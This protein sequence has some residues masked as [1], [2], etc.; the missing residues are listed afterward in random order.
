MNWRNPDR[1]EQWADRTIDGVH[2]SFGHL[3]PFDM[4][5]R[6][7]A[8]GALPPMDI[9]IRVVFD[10]HVVTE[11]VEGIQERPPA[12]DAAYWVDC[13]GNKRRFHPDRYRCSQLLSDLIRGLPDGRTK[14]YMARKANY[15]VWKPASTLP[16]GPHYQV[17]FDMYRSHGATARLVMYV[18]SAY[19][20]DRPLSVQR[21]NEKPFATICA[22]T[23]GLI[24][25]PRKGASVTPTVKARS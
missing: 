11:K 22:Q 21:Q 23:A 18:Q 5:L 25:K 15:M 4:R 20:K 7:P 13:G 1:W 6:R 9:G 8:K 12:S 3:A 2:Y 14:C 19:L 24:P 17:Y 16:E 10:C